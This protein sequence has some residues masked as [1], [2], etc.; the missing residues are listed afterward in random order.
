MYLIKKAT[1]KLEVFCFKKS[2]S[3]LSQDE[4]DLSL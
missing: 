4:S 3:E 1:Y 2:D